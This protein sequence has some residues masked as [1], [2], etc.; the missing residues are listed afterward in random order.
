MKRALLFALLL[1]LSARAEMEPVRWGPWT[2]NASDV[3]DQRGR[4]EASWESAQGSDAREFW[5]ASLQDN[6]AALEVGATETVGPLKTEIELQQDWEEELQTR[7]AQLAISVPSK[8][9]RGGISSRLD[10]KTLA[11]PDSEWELS[12]Q[13]YGG[14]V[15]TPEWHGW[16]ARASYDQ[17]DL[18]RTSRLGFSDRMSKIEAEMTSAPGQVA[19]TGRVG[20]RIGPGTLQLEAGTSTGDTWQRRYRASYRCRFLGD[21]SFSATGT[22]AWLEALEAY[23]DEVKATLEVKF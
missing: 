6:K 12:S 3:G 18:T 14:W 23:Q 21:S 13:S 8:G 22:R 11:Q 16:R 5:R 2:V 10:W 7:R 9:W 20:R 19:Y 17:Q 1:P 15:E 4:L